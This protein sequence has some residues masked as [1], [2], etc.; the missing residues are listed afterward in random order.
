MS[1][2]RIAPGHHGKHTSESEA[3]DDLRAQRGAADPV[4]GGALRRAQARDPDRAAGDRRR[5]QGRDQLARDDGDEPAG[6]D[7]HAVQ[8][9]DRDRARARLPLARPPAYPR[10]GPGR[11]SSTGRTTRTCWSSACTSWCRRRSGPS[12]TAR[13]TTSRSSWSPAAPRSSSSSCTSRPRN[14][15]SA[16]R[17]GST[18]RAKQWK[19]SDTDYSEAR[20]GTTT[21]RPT[22]RCWRNARRKHAPWYVIPSN[23]QVVPQP[24][25]VADPR[26]HAGGP[27]DEA[28]GAERRSSPAIRKEYEAAVAAGKGKK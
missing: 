27:A 16:S 24:R 14:S 10:Q 11:R 13:S 1:L 21:P 23:Q 12:A 18:T 28:A 2:K 6:H 22:R 17:S 20:A 3:A 7:G 19:I 25:G 26:R 15:W 5:R 4:A 8:A 9:A